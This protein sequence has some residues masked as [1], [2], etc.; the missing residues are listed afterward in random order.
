[1][2]QLNMGRGQQALLEPAPAVRVRRG[3]HVEAGEVQHIE[4]EEDDRGRPVGGRDLA[5]CFQL[6]ALLERGEGRAPVGAERRDLAVE[7]HALDRLLRQLRSEL[8]ERGSEVQAAPR[9]QRHLLVV[10]ESKHAVAVELGLPQPAGAGEYG[11]ARFGEHGEEL[12]RQRFLLSGGDEL[13]GGDAAHRQGLEV[14]DHKAGEDRVVFLGDAGFGDEAVLVLDEEPVLRVPGCADQRKGAFELGAP[15]RDAQLARGDALPDKALG[16]RAVVVPVTLAV[17]VGRIGAAVPHDHF[18]RAVL[19][20]GNHAFE[21]GVVVR[22]VLGHDGEAL[23]RGVERGASGNRPGLEHAVAFQPEVVVQLARRVLL[24]HEKEQS[25]ARCGRGRRLGRRV[26]GALLGIFVQQR[27]RRRRVGQHDA[28]GFGHA[29]DSSLPD[30]AR[31]LDNPS[32][33]QLL[34]GTSGFSYKEW[35]GKFY[36][37]K[38]PADGML[39][40]YA[41]HFA[42]V[43]INHTFYRMPAETMLARWAEEVPEGFSFTLKAPRRITHELR[44]KECETHV[45]EFLRRAQALGGKLGPILF[46]LPPFLTKDLP[47]LRDFLALLPAGRPAAFEFRNATWQDEEVYGTLRE[48][49]VMLCYPHT[50]EGESP[51][52]VATADCA[53]LRLR[54]TPYEDAELGEWAGRIAAL[55]VERAYVYFM[56]EDDALGAVFARKLLDFWKQRK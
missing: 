2:H 17:L 51:P 46:Q 27:C 30:R 6:H 42:T 29:R 11:V 25:L 54:R 53:Y 18:A 23:V 44:L 38:H 12:H 56:H 21:R 4:A 48:K 9:A 45:A 15:K 43:E 50:D 22:V 39:R 47:R 1:M 8:G 36:P 13:R 52:V 32:M 26:E 10:D 14:L 28:L 49:G 41:G 7:D 40:Y 35:L 3:A 24:Y 37:E 34:A 20:G 55:N 5:L 16:L 19:L 33:T 31:V